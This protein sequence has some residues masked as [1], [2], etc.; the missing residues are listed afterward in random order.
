MTN[1]RSSILTYHNLSDS[2]LVAEP[3]PD[4]PK[5]MQIEFVEREELL[6]YLKAG[7][8]ATLG[9]AAAVAFG[10]NALTHSVED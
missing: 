8:V 9:A 10:L 4:D 2:V 7:E 5:G 1:S 3:E 6:Q